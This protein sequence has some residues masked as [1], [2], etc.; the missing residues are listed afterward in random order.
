MP[1]KILFCNICKEYTLEETHCK[2]KTFI[3]SPAKF[4]PT[5]KYSKYRNIYRSKQD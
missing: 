1:H 4:S 2:E 3:R 5:D